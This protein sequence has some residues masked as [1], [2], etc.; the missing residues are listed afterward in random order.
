MSD[1]SPSAKRAKLAAQTAFRIVG[2]GDVITQPLVARSYARRGE[3]LPSLYEEFT[4]SKITEKPVDTFTQPGTYVLPK[5]AV[6]LMIG[7]TAELEAACQ[8]AN[9]KGIHFIKT[10]ENSTL[11]F[12]YARIKVSTFSSQVDTLI[13]LGADLDA[14]SAN[15]WYGYPQWPVGGKDFLTTEAKNLSE[16]A[17]SLPGYIKW[18]EE[19]DNKDKWIKA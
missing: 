18:I 4:K 10:E 5:D 19:K 17:S 11:Q 3:G 6:L 8:L 15:G 2:K 7:Q 9:E 1:T 16:D 14:P 13:A 12:R